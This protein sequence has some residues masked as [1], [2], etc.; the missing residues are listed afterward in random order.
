ML[1]KSNMHT[2][3]MEFTNMLSGIA[4]QSNKITKATRE[5]KIILKKP[6]QH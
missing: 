3:T 2:V 6:L 5:A 1:I 4:T